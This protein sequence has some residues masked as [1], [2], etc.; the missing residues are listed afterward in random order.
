MKKKMCLL[1]ASICLAGGVLADPFTGYFTDFNTADGFSDG[2]SIDEIDGWNSRAVQVTENTAVDGY[3]MLGNGPAF[4]QKGSGGSWA[5]GETITL[6]AGVF[7]DATNVRARFRLGLTD[8]IA[9]T[10]GAP[11]IGFEFDARATGD[12]YAFGGGI[13]ENTGFDVSAGQA[14]GELYTVAFT[15]SATENEINVAVSFR[16]GAYANS[17]TVT[18]ATMYSAANVY[19]HIQHNGG[20]NAG[21][22]SYAQTIPE[23]ATIGLVGL[24]G[25][26]VLFVRRRLMR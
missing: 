18:D 7:Y 21:V 24:F 16:G 9:D 23:P 15:K 6:T 20:S 8:G 1:A 4:T 26:A 13:N 14:N 25:G 2:A 3:T 12:I 19:G 22:D 10:S 11:K 17:F 5:V